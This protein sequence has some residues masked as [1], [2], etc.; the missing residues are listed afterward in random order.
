[1]TEISTINY[2]K[3]YVVTIYTG[4]H[5]GYLSENNDYTITD[6][7]NIVDDFILNNNVCVTITPTQYRYP[8]GNENGVAIGIINYPRFPKKFKEIDD[9]AMK[10][11]T[12]LM[13]ELKQ[14]RVTIVNQIETL[15]LNN[16]IIR[17]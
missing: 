15:T 7:E 12:K 8:G 13:I 16:K 3:T 2:S 5:I 14:N 6:V 1:M 10:L 4:L 11:A 17:K 9:I